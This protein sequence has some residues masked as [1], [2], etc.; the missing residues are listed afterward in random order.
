METENKVAVIR[1]ITIIG[2]YVN[3][4]LMVVKVV[5]GLFG[6]SDALVADGVH[7]FSDFAT[8]LI[9]LAFVGLAYKRAD[10]DH[11]YGHGKYETFST[12]LI[13]VALLVVAIGIGLQGIR[14]IYDAAN[15]AELP[16][17]GVLTLFV[18]LLSI[19]AKEGMY[20][21]TIRVGHRVNSSSLIA[22]AW[23]HRSDAVSSIAT[24]IG[25]S[26][27]FFLG[28]S[29][30]ICD[31]IASI[32]IAIFIAVSALGIANPSISELLE[33]SLPEAQIA[34]IER[35]IAG[36]EGVKKFHRLRTRRNGHS[37]IIDVHIKV[38]PTLT[39]T[40]G[41]EIATAVENALRAQFSDDLTTS[42]HIEPYEPK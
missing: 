29:W 34:E 2:F 28:E 26:A 18:A 24:L 22:N 25:V 10:S 35:I 37:C 32:L 12:L 38:T 17:P 41:H 27:A 15:G 1:R 6:H 33:R 11:P 8:D 42:I 40:E 4:A 31:P 36:V 21:A 30:R 5:C 14:S 20:R 19:V 16:R 3:A 7:S 9:V 23:H 39:V 13:A